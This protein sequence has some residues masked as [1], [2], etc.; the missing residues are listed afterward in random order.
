MKRSHNIILGGMTIVT[1]I[2]CII[3]LGILLFKPDAVPQFAAG[4]SGSNGK[5]AIVDYDKIYRYINDQLENQSIPQ[6]GKDAIIDYN[7]INSYI[8]QKIL[9]LPKSINGVDGQNGSSCSVTQVEV[10]AVIT[11]TDGSS[12]AIMNG[13]NGQVGPSGLTPDIRCNEKKNRWEIRYN[14]NDNYS[15]MGEKPVKCTTST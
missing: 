1:G 14:L 10:G 4:P 2:L 9:S 12:A 7:I 13:Q 8:D 15:I 3:I 11:C 5:D 6:N